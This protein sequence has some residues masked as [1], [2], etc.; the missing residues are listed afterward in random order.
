MLNGTFCIRSCTILLVCCTAFSSAF[1]TPQAAET[2]NEVINVWPS[3]L[4][5]DAKPVSQ[6]IIDAAKKKTTS[7]AIFYVET[8]VLTVYEPPA[9]KKNGTA[10]VVC[11]GGGYEMLAYQHDATRSV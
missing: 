11:P 6:K 10:V 2:T 8:P 5:A 4:P 7:E 3:G 9:D 1:A